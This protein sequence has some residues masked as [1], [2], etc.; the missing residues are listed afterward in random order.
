MKRFNS[1]ANLSCT[2]LSPACKEPCFLKIFTARSCG[3]VMFLHVSVILFTGGGEGGSVPSCITGHMTGERLCTGGL[4]SEGVSVHG[5]LCLGGCFCGWR[6]SLSRR[7]LCTGGLCSEGVSVHGSLCL[8]GCFCGWRV[9]L[10]RRGLCLGVSVWGVCPGWVVS[11]RGGGSV[12]ETPRQKPPYWNAF[13]STTGLFVTWLR[14]LKDNLY[15]F[16]DIWTVFT[17]LTTI[18]FFCFF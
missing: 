12:R 8:G 4:C 3:K 9:S 13:F 18:S 7:G 6:V 17:Y 1:L 16:I 2:A 10:S 15:K 14:C 5:S 11:V